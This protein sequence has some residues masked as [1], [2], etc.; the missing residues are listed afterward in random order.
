MELLKRAKSEFGLNNIWTVDGRICYV[1]LICYGFLRYGKHKIES[2]SYFWVCLDNLH[3]T[4]FH[5]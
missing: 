1:M 5:M 3:G 2:F 4:A